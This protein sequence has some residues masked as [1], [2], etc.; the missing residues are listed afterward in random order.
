MFRVLYLV[1][2][3]VMNFKIELLIEIYTKLTNELNE[4]RTFY[5]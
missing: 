4:Q 2:N 3:G 5:V 1:L